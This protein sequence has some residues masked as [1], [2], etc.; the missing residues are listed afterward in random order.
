MMKWLRTHSKQIMVIVVLLAMFSFVGGSALVQ[1]LSPSMDKDPIA[2]A[3]GKEITFRD[4][5]PS[6]RDT[7]ILDL[8]IGPGAWK[9]DQPDRRLTVEHWHLLAEEA[10]RA[11]IVVSDKEIDDQLANMAEQPRFAEYLD[12]LRTRYR[13]TPPEIRRA[14]RRHMA[15]MKHAEFLGGSAVPSEPQVRHYVR[16]TSDKVS[17]EFVALDAATFA[18]GSQPIPEEQL[19]AQFEKHKDADPATSETGFGYRHPRRV[20]AQFV[21]ARVDKI[22]AQVKVSFEEVKNYWKANKAKYTKTVYETPPAASQPAA[23][24]AAS[25]PAPAPVPKQVEKTLVEARMDVENELRNRAALRLA[26]QAASRVIE[27]LQKPWQGIKV[28]AETGFKPIPEPARDID[29]LRRI[30]EETARELAIPLEYHETGLLSEEELGRRSEL[31]GAALAGEGPDGLAFAEYAFRVP[32]FYKPDER[33]ETA[34][35]LQL[36]QGPDAPLTATKFQ[37]RGMGQFRFEMPKDRF[38]VFRVVEVEEAKP[39]ASL[40]EVRAAVLRDVRRLKGLAAAEPVAREI[41]AVARRLGLKAGYELFTDLH[42]K[43]GVN[44]VNTPMPF[45]RFSRLP[46]EKLR[47]AMI[48]GGSTLGPTEVP[49][50]GASQ[51]FIDACF[52]MIEPGWTPPPVEE[53]AGSPRLQ[54]A[55]TRP[56]M[57]PP[58]QLRIVALPKLGKVCVVQRIGVARTDQQEFEKGLRDQA[59]STLMGERGAF[60]LARWFNPENVE[61]RCGFERITTAG[62]IPYEGLAEDIPPPPQF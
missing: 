51:E 32:P 15:I 24:Q 62:Q 17:V 3:F 27:A 8:V 49:G 53:P 14:F 50:I 60:L 55:T 4:L 26:E 1:I 58:P 9:Y 18:D 2:R 44:A 12:M 52:E 19:L 57:E 31:Q 23:S 36:F 43:T 13:I 16:D 20:R 47:D 45:T 48:A 41:L 7:E 11:G 29:L 30:Y 35:C 22:Q 56:A 34:L 40:E 38:I 54:L 28:D 59:Y 33:S 37:L 42:T 21:L 25:Q 5:G 46:Q 61:A 6:R 10:E 39:A